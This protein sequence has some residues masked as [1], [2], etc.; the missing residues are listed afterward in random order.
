M[1]L[2]FNQLLREVGLNTAQVRLLSHETRTFS[3]RTPYTVWRRDPAAFERYQ[4]TQ[5]RSSRAYFDSPYWASFVVTPDGRTLFVGV[6]AVGGVAPV[7]AGWRHELNDQ[8][9]DPEAEAVRGA[10]VKA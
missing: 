7:P 3:G 8:P 9:L 2:T 10:G 4:S 1:P 6:Y 5:D